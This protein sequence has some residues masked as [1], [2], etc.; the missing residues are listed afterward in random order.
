MEDL[1]NTS[2]R[3]PVNSCRA[4]EFRSSNALENHLR[5][6]ERQL[7]KCSYC[8]QYFTTR[9][10]RETHFF[11]RSQCSKLKKVRRNTEDLN[12]YNNNNKNNYQHDDHSFPIEEEQ[13]PQITDPPSF[14]VD[15]K[16]FESGFTVN[17]ISRIKRL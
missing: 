14:E 4:G 8:Q 17:L 11:E 13:E 6:H 10:E 5:K 9:F 2:L 15:G 1:N 7:Y 3:C 16:K 12:N